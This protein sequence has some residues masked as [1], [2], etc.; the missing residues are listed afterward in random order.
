MLLPAAVGLLGAEH[1]LDGHEG[2]GLGMLLEQAIQAAYGAASMS[3]A[4][5]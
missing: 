2:A 3:A 4:A 5:V 1:G